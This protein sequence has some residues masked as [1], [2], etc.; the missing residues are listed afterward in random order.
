MLGEAVFRQNVMVFPEVPIAVIKARTHASP[1]LPSLPLLQLSDLSIPP[2]PHTFGCFVCWPA[3]ATSAS[4]PLTCAIYF[5]LLSSGTLSVMG[6]LPLP[7]HQISDV[8][9]L[10]QQ[11]QSTIHACL[12]CL[13]Q[14]VDSSLPLSSYNVSL[15]TSNFQHAEG[16]RLV[17]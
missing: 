8:P 1:D 7:P 17:L 16:H 6:L 11:S 15:R 5:H 14:T 9:S 12:D 2:S 13:S 4:H 3:L 10:L